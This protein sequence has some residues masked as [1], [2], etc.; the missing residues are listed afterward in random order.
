MKNNI[1]IKFTLATSANQRTSSSFPKCL[2]ERK[3]C[4]HDKVFC[5]A[6]IDLEQRLLCLLSANVCLRDENS[7][8]MNDAN[9]LLLF[10]ILNAA[11]SSQI[12]GSLASPCKYEYVIGR[13]ACLATSP[14][15]WNECFGVS[16]NTFASVWHPAV[17]KSEPVK[18]AEGIGVEKDDKLLQKSQDLD[19]SNH[20]AVLSRFWCSMAQNVV[21]EKKNN[22]CKPPLLQ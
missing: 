15:D 17:Q 18:D 13:R 19:A 12:R 11:R 21:P 2:R 22:K 10:S 8:E 16:K 7:I 14:P 9:V 5:S 6:L 20:C 1:L 4:V 3:V